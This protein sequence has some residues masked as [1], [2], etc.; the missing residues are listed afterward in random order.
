MRNKYSS[1]FITLNEN[2]EKVFISH[3]KQ[4]IQNVLTEHQL[5]LLK[6]NRK[7]CFCMTFKSDTKKA[8]FLHIIKNPRRIAINKLLLG[9]HLLRIETGRNTVPKTAEDLRLCHVCQT[10][11]IE[12]ELH[13]LFS[14]THYDNLRIKLFNELTEKY[15]FF[16]DLDINSKILFLFNSID[17]VICRSIAAFVYDC[18]NYRQELLFQKRL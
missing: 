14:C 10:N 4:N 5:S 6:T 18:M 16:K 3:I 2:N 1:T 15:I 7:L 11:E 8:D 13:F 12:N 17:P 9:N